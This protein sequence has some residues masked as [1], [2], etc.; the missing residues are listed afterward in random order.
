MNPLARGIEELLPSRISSS[1]LC[2]LVIRTLLILSSLVVA[3]LVPFFGR[4]P[5]LAFPPLEKE[6]TK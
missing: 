6:H 3:F 1:Y 2:F 5:S 4:W